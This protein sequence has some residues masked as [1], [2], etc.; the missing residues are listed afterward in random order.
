[1]SEFR[2]HYNMVEA[3]GTPAYEKWQT[4]AL[5]VISLV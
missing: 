2:E 5:L 4:L 1:M 3:G